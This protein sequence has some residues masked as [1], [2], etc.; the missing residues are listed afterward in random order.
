MAL[1]AIPRRNQLGYRPVFR[2][3]LFFIV[4]S[5][6]CGRQGAGISNIQ[7]EEG[8]RAE[9]FVG[10]PFTV[11]AH[12]AAGKAIDH[13]DLRIGPVSGEGWTFER[14]FSEGIAGKKAVSFAARVEIPKDAEPGSY[15]L[16]LRLTEDDGSVA[17]ESADF[18]IAIDSTIP[19]ASDLDV[20]INAAGN[21]LHLETEL[22]AP[23]GIKAVLV[24]IKGDA[25]STGFT[26]NEGEL[27]GQLTHHFHEHVHVEEAPAGTYRVIL[28][29]EDR[30]G[31]SAKTEGTF[32]KG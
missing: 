18:Q 21:D 31:R 1:L 24:E 6:G 14:P 20:G 23:S 25:W 27:V 29:V 28:T 5:A 4:L 26:F 12:V 10:Q 16:T 15:R 2:L 3:L 22:I 30:K 19:T 8:G 11:S 7:V 32:T 9:V 13:V 17:E